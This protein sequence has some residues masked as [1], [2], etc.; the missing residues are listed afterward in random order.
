VNLEI[1]K[2]EIMDEIEQRMP[3]IRDS[4]LVLL[5]SKTAD[6][7]RTVEGKFRLR[8]EII[9]RVNK[10]ISNGKV[11]GAYFTEFVMQ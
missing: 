9:S 8:D 11:K 1:E 7:V 2:T 3:Q 6:E 10:L 4:I 5:S